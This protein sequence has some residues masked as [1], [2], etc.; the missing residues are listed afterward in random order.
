M[1]WLVLSIVLF[2]AA[3]GA[4]AWFASRR[5]ARRISFEAREMWATSR[6]SRPL[7][8][9]QVDRLPVP[10]RRYFA[11]ALRG[12]ERTVR[13]L[14]L[15]HGGTF[16]AK[17]DGP[18]LPIQGEQYFSADPPGFVWWGRVRLAPGVWFD[19]RDRSVKGL[20]G[21][22]VAAESVIG[23]IDARGS[24][25]DQGALLRLLGEMIWLPTALFDTRYVQWSPVGDRRARATL[26]VDGLAVAG[27]FEFDQEGLPVAFF[28]NRYRDLGDG[29]QALTPFS[30]SYADY[31]E[32]DGL[33]VPFEISGQWHVGDQI[34]PYASFKVERLDY[35]IGAPFGGR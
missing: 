35:D 29:T 19:A 32:V 14:R 17:L 9:G 15:R 12:R 33:L 25:I 34:L 30:G 26:R 31:R 4:A 13:T 6:D 27:E 23:L 16:R 21:M 28:A 20:G 22:L 1:V 5:F 10:V 18:W 7:D 24:G 8:R 2:A 11:R 3:V